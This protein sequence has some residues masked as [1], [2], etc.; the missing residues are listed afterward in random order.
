[1]SAIIEIEESTRQKY[2]VYR[3]DQL[4]ASEVHSLAALDMFVRKDARL[5]HADGRAAN[6]LVI[7][8]FGFKRSG[9][10]Y[11]GRVRWDSKLQ[12]NASPQP[13]SSHDD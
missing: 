2:A 4:I 13:E 1:M 3:D 8:S 11:K 6:Y 10:H 12:L 7:G 5:E 9:T